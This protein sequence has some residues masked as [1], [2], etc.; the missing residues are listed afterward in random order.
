MSEEAED[1]ARV[2]ANLT[3][4]ALVDVTLANFCE[5]L[6]PL[7]PEITQQITSMLE[8]YLRNQSSYS[9]LVDEVSKH[10]HVISPIE[11]LRSIVET[12]SDPIS[13]PLPAAQFP[14][15]RRPARAWTAQED[16][17]LLAGI[18][19]FGIE[20][21]TAI[22]KFVGNGRSRTQCSQRWYRGLNPNIS[23]D[24]WSSEEEE[25]L[26]SLVDTSGITSWT[27]IA[28]K[29]G[30]R[31][32]VQCRYR[33]RQLLKRKGAPDIEEPADPRWMNSQIPMQPILM[34]NYPG[35]FPVYAP[36]PMQFVRPPM[37]YSQQPMQFQCQMP[38]IPGYF[39]PGRQGSEHS[40]PGI[41]LP[42]QT[43]SP[44][45]TFTQSPMHF[46]SLKIESQ[47]TD[48]G[49]EQPVVGNPIRAP[50]FDGRLFSVC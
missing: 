35:T 47:P 9:Q 40:S 3:I 12:G 21:W 1:R 19:K 13:P 38:T 23:K 39:S 48:V 6:E 44:T 24:Q 37:L 30:G 10:V 5:V 46:P 32:D 33:Y 49:H 45:F 28:R 31:S 29:L 18:L 26:L 50:A 42:A 15:S 20:N 41:P 2:S 25:R 7:T 8:S 34:M 11:K 4:K 14:G 27:E 17:R 22:S 16:Q 36:P 43:A